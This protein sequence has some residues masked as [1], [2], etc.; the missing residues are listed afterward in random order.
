LYAENSSKQYITT[1]TF[2]DNIWHH[3][4]F[5]W[6]S[7]V[8]KVYVDNIEQTVTKAYDF[9]FTSIFNG[10][11]ISILG[12]YSNLIIPFNG[13][14]SNAQIWN[15]ALTAEEIAAIYSKGRGGF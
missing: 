1:S 11:A 5:T 3:I 9:D 15:R 8:L 10:S 7:G 13:Q 6:N 14:I 2:N 4:G 12:M